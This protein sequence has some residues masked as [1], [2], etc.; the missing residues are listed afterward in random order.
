MKLRLGLPAGSMQEATFQLFRRAGYG[1]SLSARSYVPTI[2]DPEIEC[3]LLRAQEIPHYVGLGVFDAGLSGLD[4]IMESGAEVVEAADLVYSRASAVKARWVLAAARDGAINSVRDLAG[5]RVATELVK[6][7]QQYFERNGVNALVEYSWGATEVKVPELADAIVE[8]TETGS[9]LRANNL[10]IVDTVLETNVKF[11]ANP[12]AWQDAWKRQK[13]ENLAVLLQGALRAD[14]K[15]GLK[16][17]VSAENLQ[18]VL[19]LLPAMKGPTVSSLMGGAWHA[20]ETVAD[21]KQVRDLIPE[22]K[23]AGAQDI[24]EYPLN[25]VIP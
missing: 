3:L 12:L 14:A 1:V 4:W 7:T 9:S 22:L 21:E 19:S 15:V 24:I 2:D 10:K 25:K 18:A 11:V 17:N 5:K 13:I 8:I 20:V 23:R 16:M 6:V